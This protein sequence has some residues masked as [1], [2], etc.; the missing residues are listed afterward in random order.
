MMIVNLKKNETVRM[1]DTWVTFICRREFKGFELG[2]KA[3]PSKSV[4]REEIY[5]ILKKE[6][7]RLSKE[8]LENNQN[9]GKY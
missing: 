2:V 8:E 4:H 9:N 5:T 3:P 6:K 7:E 1:G